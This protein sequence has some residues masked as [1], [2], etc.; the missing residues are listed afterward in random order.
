MKMAPR[1]DN[2]KQMMLKSDTNDI[3]QSQAM[4]CKGFKDDPLDYTSR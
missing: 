1:N 3:K 4:F 2:V